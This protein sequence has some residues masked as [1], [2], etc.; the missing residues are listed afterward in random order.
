MEYK[1]AI[2]EALTG[3]RGSHKFCGNAEFAAA[4]KERAK[5]ESINEERKTG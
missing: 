5:S 1:N 4:V 3:L 2:E